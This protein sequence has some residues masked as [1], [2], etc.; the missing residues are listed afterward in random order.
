MQGHGAARWEVSRL[1]PARCGSA[2]ATAGRAHTARH[3]GVAA[4]SKFTRKTESARV[5]V[6]CLP[7]VG[8]GNEVVCLA[9]SRGTETCPSACV[10]RFLVQQVDAVR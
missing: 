4:F 6:G 1:Y 2:A 9:G 8:G 7:G 10:T 3:V 5:C